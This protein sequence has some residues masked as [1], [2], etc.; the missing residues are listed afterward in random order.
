MTFSILGHC[1]RTGQIGLALT[2]VTMGV[3][4]TSPFYGY[5]G[6][7]A[8]AQARG[9][10]EAAVAALRALDQG[11]S[12]EAALAAVQAADP[13][14]EERQIAVM[15]RD[16]AVIARTGARNA[17]WAGELRGEDC[18]AFGNVLSG[19]R[20]IEAMAGRF[21]ATAGD[22]LGSRLIAALE[23][24]RDAGGQSPGPGRHYRERGAAVRV[25][26]TDAQPNIAALDLRV[27]MHA[28]AVA[29]LRRIH[30]IYQP[31]MALRALRAAN[32]EK[33]PVLWEW[34]ASN[35]SANPPPPLFYEP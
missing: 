22:P 30:D 4:G 6:D 26:G 33:M 14:F 25:V 27:D 29:E 16:G 28:D 5:G 21:A 13:H 31:M 1:R 32:P 15:R 8:V 12:L 17:A 3:G 9:N 20:V 11:A 2:S 23:A 18:L 24:G 19:P 7:I 10:P 34:E 35:M